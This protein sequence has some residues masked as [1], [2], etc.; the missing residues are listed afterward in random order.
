MSAVRVRHRP[1]TFALRSGARLPV[2]EALANAAFGECRPWRGRAAN[3]SEDP[4]ILGKH[5]SAADA[6][7]DVV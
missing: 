4:S 3:V 6:A 7:A 1:P 5:P 2:E